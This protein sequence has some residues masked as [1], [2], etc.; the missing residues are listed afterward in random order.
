M[1]NNNGILK[2]YTGDMIDV[3]N[4]MVKDGRLSL[5]EADNLIYS[6]MKDS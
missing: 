6:L 1:E 2:G 4:S 5:I 3:I